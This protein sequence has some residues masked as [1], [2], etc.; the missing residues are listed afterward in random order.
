M[1]S[2]LIAQTKRRPIPTLAIL[3]FVDVLSLSLCGLHFANHQAHE[4]YEVLYRTVPLT[5]SVTHVTG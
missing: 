1:F 2:Y 5:V 4:N 3:L